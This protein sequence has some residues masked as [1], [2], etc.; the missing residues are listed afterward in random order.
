MRI[1]QLFAAKEFLYTFFQ[2]TDEGKYIP[3]SIKW[4]DE[5]V[6]NWYLWSV[7]Y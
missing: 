3:G 4:L 2:G 6:G 5:D 1:R 7:H